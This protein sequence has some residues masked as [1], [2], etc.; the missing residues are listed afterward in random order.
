MF[1]FFMYLE[2]LFSG[3]SW[4]GFDVTF[5]LFCLCSHFSLSRSFGVAST[6]PTRLPWLISVAQSSHLWWHW[7]IISSVTETWV[8]STRSELLGTLTP[9]LTH[10]HWAPPLSP[11]LEPDSGLLPTRPIAFVQL[12]LWVSVLFLFPRDVFII[13]ILEHSWV[14]LILPYNMWSIIPTDF[15]GK[16]IGI[17]LTLFYFLTFIFP[18][19]DF[20]ICLD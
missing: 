8:A 4:M 10:N 5:F 2:F 18:W 6:W 12:P 1:F 9:S 11:Q 20:Y 15:L 19:P 13:D 17:I 14:S 7:D 3:L 16:E